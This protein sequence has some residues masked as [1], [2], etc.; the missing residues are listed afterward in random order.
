MKEY[1]AWKQLRVDCS[2]IILK[3]K[4]RGHGFVCLLVGYISVKKNYWKLQ[5]CFAGADKVG[6]TVLFFGPTL[7]VISLIFGERKN[8][9]SYI[10]KTVGLSTIKEILKKYVYNSTVMF[11]NILPFCLKGYSET[12]KV[13]TKT[14]IG[15]KTLTN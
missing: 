5:F 11:L 1:F 10:L 8:V 7:I 9:K 14:S 4:N 2:K 12:L 15:V 3:E 6:K 13:L